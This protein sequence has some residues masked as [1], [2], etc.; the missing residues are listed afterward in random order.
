MKVPDNGR[1]RAQRPCSLHVCD[2]SECSASSASCGCFVATVF[3][4]LS[5]LLYGVLL[6]CTATASA[7]A[8]VGLLSHDVRVCCLPLHDGAEQSSSNVVMHSLS[9]HCPRRVTVSKSCDELTICNA[10]HPVAQPIRQS[11]SQ[12][13]R[14]NACQIKSRPG[15]QC[16]LDRAAGTLGWLQYLT[17]G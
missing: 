13:Q 9:M 4:C 17:A 2:S 1:Q 8:C 3:L 7:S 16:L 11:S 15:F 14:N 10:T 5:G 12:P 6:A